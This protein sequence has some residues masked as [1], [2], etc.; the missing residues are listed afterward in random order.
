MTRLCK[1]CGEPVS[2]NKFVAEWE[3]GIVRHYHFKCYMELRK[4]RTD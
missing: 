4:V 1:V 3:N 2:G